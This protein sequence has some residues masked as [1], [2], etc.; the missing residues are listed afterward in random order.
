ME[1]QIITE[2]YGSDG[3]PRGSV[4]RALLTPFVSSILAS[5]GIFGGISALFVGIV[6]V[7]IHGVLSHDQ[8][9]DHVGTVLLIAA[10]PMIL[11]GSLFV[12]EIQGK[13]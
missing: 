11:L 9:F 4:R 2:S 12:D 10:I 3:N 8:I 7:I 13:K 5:L 6:S 1:S